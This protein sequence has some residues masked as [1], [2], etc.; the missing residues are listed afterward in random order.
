MIIYLFDVSYFNEEMSFAS[1]CR[2]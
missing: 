2:Y 1:Y